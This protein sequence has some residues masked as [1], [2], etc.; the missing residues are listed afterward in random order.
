MPDETRTARIEPSGLVPDEFENDPNIIIHS[1]ASA[2]IRDEQLETIGVFD[3]FQARSPGGRRSNVYLFD[4]DDEW[5]Y[6]DKK[7]GWLVLHYIDKQTTPDNNRLALEVQLYI[8]PEGISEIPEKNLG[9][10]TDP[11]IDR[12]HL[13]WGL[14]SSKD[15]IIYDKKL[16]RFFKFDLNKQTI[17]KGPKLN[18]RDSHKPI[19]IGWLKKKET[20]SYSRLGWNPPQIKDPDK[21]TDTER[22]IVEFKP[23]MPVF[24][25]F[26]AGLYLLVLDET[27]RIDRLDKKTLTFAGTA[28]RLPVPPTLFGYE[29]TIMPRG[30]LAY[31]VWPLSLT[32][33]FFETTEEKQE[34]K[35]VFFGEPPGSSNPPPTRIEK[36]YLGLLAASLSHDGTSLALTAYD[37]NGVQNRIE[38]TKLTRYRDGRRVTS[39]P[40]SKAVLF[41]APWAPATT[42]CKY[43][44]ENLHPPILSLA[45]YF[46]AKYFEAASGHRALFLLPNSFIA[47]RARAG[48]KNI[49]VAERFF[50]AL[51]LMSPAIILA[52]VLA[53]IVNKD[54]VVV[55]LSKNARLYWVF[56][57]L[58]FGP[59]AYI[60][61]R[62][63]RPK[64]TLVT[65]QNC[66]KPRRPDMDKCHRCKSGWHVPELTPPLWRVLD[67]TEQIQLNASE[68]SPLADEE[69][70]TTE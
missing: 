36:K 49:N 28:G 23:I 40:S 15:L 55:G 20:F 16:R 3:Y 19:Q 63:T 21:N 6:F 4:S 43:L 10:F 50:S 67:G 70:I 12:S 54:A 46:T 35:K 41:E 64:M 7:T 65:C 5:I 66:G 68:A 22:S 11:I 17:V 2:R 9:R 57:T 34:S 25:D 62:L 61:Y 13:K 30:L 45:S 33:H 59:V 1:Q 58:A 32:T 42:I 26:Y 27:G 8:G 44:T 24:Y 52:I 53:H 51:S 47:L 56:G 14:N 37:E 38:H 48:N 31:D 69:E 29:S 18:K 39:I 60:T